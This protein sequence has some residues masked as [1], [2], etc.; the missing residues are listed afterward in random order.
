VG[1]VRSI[2][3]SIEQLVVDLIAVH[4]GVLIEEIGDGIMAA[5]G[6]AAAPTT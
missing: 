2:E 4:R 6:S 5:F 1:G 3:R